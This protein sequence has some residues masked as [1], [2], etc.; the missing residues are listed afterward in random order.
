M[1][2]GKVEGKNTMIATTVKQQENLK[3]K[4]FQ[5]MNKKQCL[6]SIE[7]IDNQP[8]IFLSFYF[9]VYK[10]VELGD[11]L[12]PTWPPWS[13]PSTPP[14]SPSSRTSLL[15]RSPSRHL[16]TATEYCGCQR[17]VY[18]MVESWRMKVCKH[19]CRFMISSR[20]TVWT[21]SSRSCIY[22]GRWSKECKGCRTCRSVVA[23]QL[24]DGCRVLTV[25]TAPLLVLPLVYTS[26]EG[27]VWMATRLIAV[28]Q[29]YIYSLKQV[30]AYTVPWTGLRSGGSGGYHVM[31][32]PIC[33]NSLA[34][35]FAHKIHVVE[36]NT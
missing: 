31:L 4:T 7:W 19:K 16:S 29:V 18:F 9:N 13:A 32:V 15:P 2:Q 22:A 35:F 27:Q 20:D 3:E 1:K 14:S 28:R 30:G 12:Q 11:Q 34:I 10:S 25:H 8:D 33:Q 5:D 6:E 24:S 36:Y 21:P 26:T 23:G 17:M